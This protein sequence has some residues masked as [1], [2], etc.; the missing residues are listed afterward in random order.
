MNRAA[1][2]GP[3][4]LDDLAQRAMIERTLTPG[5]GPFNLY[6][7]VSGDN[8]TD[9][10]AR[11]AIPW[12]SNPHLIIRFLRPLPSAL[13][14]LDHRLFGYGA[15]APHLVSLLWWVGAVLA[16]YA[17]YRTAAGPR[18][19]LVA[20][21]LFALSPTL[22]IPLVWLANRDTLLTLTFGALAL[23]FYVRWRRD[24]RWQSGFTAAAAFGASA[25]TGEYA[26]CL[27]GYVVAFELC[28]PKESYRRRLTGALPAGVP[29]ILY[30]LTHVALG[31]GTTGCGFYRDP[32]THPGEYLRAL[33]RVLSVL[34]ASAWLGVD[35][36]SSWV[37]G[38]SIPCR[39]DLGWRRSRP[40]YDMERPSPRPPRWRRGLAGQLAR[41]WR[42]SRSPRPSPRGVSSASR[43]SV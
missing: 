22:A 8:R 37:G 1:L 5:R 25:L 11:G 23:T 29:L 20:V 12:W 15:L 28:H 32:I 34:L 24:R 35:E 31:Y 16:A 13:V 39:L 41:C 36:R 6:D 30:A 9:L 40:G 4:V 26:L 3:L 10:L 19:A 33:P 38:A 7:F 18:A 42:C 21:V 14:W 2:R 43:L 27:G 17:L